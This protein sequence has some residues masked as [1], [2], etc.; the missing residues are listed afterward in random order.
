MLR[1]N[2]RGFRPSMAVVPS[3]ES[4]L[5]AESRKFFSERVDTSDLIRRK[6]PQADLKRQN[7]RVFEVCIAA[8]LFFLIITFQVA[9]E[10]SVSAAAITQPEIKIEVADIPVTQQLKQSAPPPRPTVPVP[11]ESEDVPEDLTIASTEID[12]T[13]IPLP[14]PPPE[15]DEM[16]IFVAYDEPPQIIG[17]M[18]ELQKHLKYPRLAQAAG[19]EGIVFV[20][21]LVS[22]RGETERMEIIRAKPEK[23]GFEESAMAAIQKV[24]WEPAKQRDRKI[25]VWVSIPVQFKLVSS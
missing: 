15:E 24:K 23:M 18:G 9:K 3:S 19:V 1:S 13:Q 21:V 4:R 17:G 12:L 8:T 2:N 7:R 14:P 25:R 16:P 10:F 20:K 11:T 5:N 6:Q 22:A